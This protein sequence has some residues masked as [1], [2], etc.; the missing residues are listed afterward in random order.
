MLTSIFFVAL[1]RYKTQIILKWYEWRIEVLK[2]QSKDFWDI[3]DFYSDR[4]DEK[5][6]RKWIS[7]AFE[8]EKKRE[9]YLVLKQTYSQKGGG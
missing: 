3:A 2:K 9:E 7:K 8:A 6:A 4:R 1:M 5:N